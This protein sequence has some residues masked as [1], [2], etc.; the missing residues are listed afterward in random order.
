[1]NKE[2]IPYPEKA[3]ERI[4]ASKIIGRL[5]Q[6]I[7]GEIDLSATQVQAARVL[8]NKTLPDL[9]AVDHTGEIGAKHSVDKQTIE[10]ATKS[11]VERINAV[12][13]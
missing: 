12:R 9:K 6:H 13:G 5:I 1:M 11:L 10:Q 8:L 3:R 2:K 7:D 4:K